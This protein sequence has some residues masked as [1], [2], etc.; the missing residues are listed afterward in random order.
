MIESENFVKKPSARLEYPIHLSAT[1]S[2][3]L[4]LAASPK[5][6]LV[7]RIVAI[8]L[9]DRRRSTIKGNQFDKKV[10]YAVSSSGGQWGSPGKTGLLLDFVPQSLQYIKASALFEYRS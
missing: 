3:R 10:L 1:R 4:K 5:A 8:I 9:Q 2:T 6:P 7:P